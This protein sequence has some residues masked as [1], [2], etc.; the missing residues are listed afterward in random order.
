MPASEN[1]S[2][3]LQ[4]RGAEKAAPEAYNSYGEGDAEA[5][6]RSSWTFPTGSRGFTMIE[7]VVVFG[8]IAVVGAFTLIFS[9]D[10][11]R[12]SSF[13]SDRDLFVA[14]LQR[15]R[16]LSMNNMCSDSLCSDGSSHGVKI[17]S[18]GTYVIFEGANYASRHQNTD[19]IFKFNTATTTTFNEIVFSALFGTASVDTIVLTGQGHSST[20]KL[21]T[22]GRICSD[23]PSC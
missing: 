17:L 6:Q 3:K 2:E 9:M 20:I 12:G 11:Y 7:I 13:R 23:N 14:G 8:L 21:N 5:P 22:E 15:A 10:A 1:L 19:S 4:I 18:N 16:A